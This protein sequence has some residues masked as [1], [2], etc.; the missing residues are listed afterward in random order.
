MHVR[1]VARL[2]ST[3]GGQISGIDKD[4]LNDAKGAMFD[5]LPSRLPYSFTAPF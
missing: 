3:E 4:T 5:C 1:I 2:S